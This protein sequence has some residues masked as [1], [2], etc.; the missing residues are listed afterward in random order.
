MN[1]YIYLF[2]SRFVYFHMNG[3]IENVIEDAE[4][5]E[6]NLIIDQLIDKISLRFYI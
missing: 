6:L 1:I 4:T 3:E 2:I 5:R